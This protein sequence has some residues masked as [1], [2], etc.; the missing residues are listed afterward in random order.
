ML[1]QEI[2]E[3]LIQANEQFAEAKNTS[4]MEVKTFELYETKRTNKLMNSKL[5]LRI[6]KSRF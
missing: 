1:N 2:K 5:Q 3:S 6:F 4:A